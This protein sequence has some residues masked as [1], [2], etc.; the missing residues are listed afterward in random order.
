MLTALQALVTNSDLSDPANVKSI[1]RAAEVLSKM[2]KAK[3]APA[4]KELILLVREGNDHDIVSYY[5]SSMSERCIFWL[6]E[7]DISLV[8]KRQVSI[9]SEAHAGNVLHYFSISNAQE[10]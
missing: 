3:R 10:Y 5:F 9:I 1:D 7:I 6:E 8:T 2:A 4:D